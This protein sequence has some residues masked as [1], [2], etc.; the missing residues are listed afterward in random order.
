MRKK[1]YALILSASMLIPSLSQA[2][3]V[4]YNT[5]DTLMNYAAQLYID[6][7]ISV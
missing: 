1:L 6:Q 7:D 2:A 5:V 4:E 3:S